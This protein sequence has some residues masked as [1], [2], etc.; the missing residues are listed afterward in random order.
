MDCGRKQGA[1]TIRQATPYTPRALELDSLGM[2]VNALERNGFEVH[3]VEGWREHYQQTCA[4]WAQRLYEA[5]ERAAA[6]AG[7][8]KTRLWLIYLAGCSLA[9]ERSSVGIF[10]T[11]ASKRDKG[12]SGLPPTRADLYS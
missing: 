4:H 1:R 2:S 8:E 6:E 11:L 12:P 7:W 9:F 5:R 10:Q 3:D